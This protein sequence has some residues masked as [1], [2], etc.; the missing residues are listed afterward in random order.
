[1]MASI[2]QL[3]RLRTLIRKLPIRDEQIIM[4]KHKNCRDMDAHEVRED[5]K[6]HDRLVGY[7]SGKGS[8]RMGDN[9][10]MTPVPDTITGYTHAYDVV[11]SYLKKLIK[12]ASE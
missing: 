11:D 10:Y 6:T 7:G 2:N 1:M 3:R 9:Q 5:A 12:E 8:I 4:I